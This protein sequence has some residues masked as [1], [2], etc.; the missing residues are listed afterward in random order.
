MTERKSKG[1]SVFVVED[2]RGVR[3][4]RFARDGI[5]QSAVV[6]GDPGHLVF[7]YVKGLIAGFALRPDAKSVLLVGLGGGSFPMF[8]RRHRPDLRIDV[9]ELDPVVVEV[10]TL[11][12]GFRQDDALVVTVDDGRRFIESGGDGAR[13]DIIVL[14]A[15]GPESIP[16]HLATRGFFEAVRARL[17]PDGVVVSNLWS[18]YANP[19]YPSMLRTLEAA[20]PEVHVVA[21]QQSESRLVFAFAEPEGLTRARFV[22]QAVALR[23]A[24]GLRFDLATM[25]SRGH[26]GPW[27]LPPGGEVLED[28]PSP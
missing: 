3:R 19:R 25:I 21:P 4:L 24:W 15:Y 8:V 10:A 27:E 11:H 5:D 23:K 18:E 22:E 6:M 2:E 9:V 1:Y 12:L 13:W 7:A 26:A 16:E 28:P 20:F 14:D 17:E